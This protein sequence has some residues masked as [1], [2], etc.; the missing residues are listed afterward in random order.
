MEEICKPKEPESIICSEDDHVVLVPTLPLNASTNREGLTLEQLK[1][2]LKTPM[3][4]GFWCKPEHVYEGVERSYNDTLS[5]K[6][7]YIYIYTCIISQIII[8]ILFDYC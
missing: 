8:D 3:Q 6:V 2:V 4:A 5:F 7:T 1:T